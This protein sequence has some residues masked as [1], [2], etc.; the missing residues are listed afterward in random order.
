MTSKR[1]RPSVAAIAE[2]ATPDTAPTPIEA[3]SDQERARI[4]AEEVFREE[5]RKSLTPPK[6][7]SQKIAGFLNAPFFVAL[8]VVGG[9]AFISWAWQW[10]QDRR[11]EARDHERIEA[12]FVGRMN[13][14][15]Q[16]VFFDRVAISFAPS[17]EKK[18]KK[19]EQLYG[20]VREHIR[21]SPAAEPD[22]IIGQYV[23]YR[24]SNLL[25]LATTI[26]EFDP[27]YLH[28]PSVVQDMDRQTAYFQSTYGD[29]TGQPTAVDFYVRG[30]I[31]TLNPLP[32]E[33]REH[34]YSAFRAPAV[35]GG[36]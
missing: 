10:R 2:D 19:I 28:V 9:V 1:P 13:E 21:K 7:R 6:S 20:D 8:L 4:Q 15:A 23:D 16:V 12:E 32:I 5:V 24:G 11:E 18:R 31:G 26:A 36:A 33:A 14:L 27:S 30:M 34:I 22:D 17:D 29:V 3:L 25:I 35:L